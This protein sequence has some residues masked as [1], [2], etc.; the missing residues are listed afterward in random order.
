[1]TPVELFKAGYTD[2]VCV[3]PPGAQLAPN[4]SLKDLGKVPGLKGDDGWHGYNWRKHVPNLRQI[5]KWESWDA[6]TGLR[7]DQF[8]AVDIDV[9]DER[10]ARVVQQVAHRVLGGAPVRRSVGSRRLLPYRTSTPFPRLALVMTW[11]GASHKVEILAAGRQYLIAGKHPSGSDYRWETP[12]PAQAEQLTS[13]DRDKVERFL[14]ELEVQLRRVS[15]M[16]LERVGG[17]VEPAA[18]PPAQDELAAPSPEALEALV[19][20]IPN[21]EEDR[22]GYVRFGH[23]VRAAGGEEAAY[24]FAEWASRWED[25]HNDPDTVDRDYAGF[26]GPYKIGWDWLVRYAAE[27]CRIDPQDEFEADLEAVPPAETGSTIPADTSELG[28]ARHL[29]PSMQDQLAYIGDEKAGYWLAWDGGRW[30]R[31]GSMKPS[32]VVQDACKALSE[33]LQARAD[34]APKKEGAEWAKVAAHLKTAAGIRAVMS[35]LRSGVNPKQED[36]DVD[37][38]ALNTPAGIVDLRTGSVRPSTPADMLTRITAVAPERGPMPLFQKF[39]DESTGGDV[40]LQGFLQRMFGYSLSGDTSAKHLWFVW[41]E[42]DTGKSTFIRIMD[43]IFGEYAD[44]VDVEAFISTDRSRIP[45][46]LARLPGVR[47]VTATEP[48]ANKSWDEKRIKAITGGDNIDARFL[49]GQNFSYKP[50]FKIVIIGNHEP[51]VRTVDTAMLRRIQIVP[52]NV[53]VPREKQVLGL[54]DRIIAEEGP[55][56]MQWLVDGCLQWQE[57]GLRPP[58]CV[59]AKTAQYGEDEDIVAQFLAEMCEVQEGATVTRNEVYRAWSM[60][61]RGRGYIPGGEKQLKGALQPH[62]ARLGFKDSRIGDRRLNGYKN[63]SLRDMNGDF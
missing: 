39:L 29:E 26:G 7:G 50:Q 30:Q 14:S 13:V 3:V 53:P 51:E 55:A 45:A 10:L 41:G 20:E 31:N 52:L 40:E 59:Q 4:T 33:T 43:A 15:G 34:A 49:Y 37:P 61:C 9:D 57:G 44:S 56:V 63:L 18:A 60:W 8:P 21:R 42:A 2:L 23:A 17:G 27:N 1:V 5:K 47:L 24:V 32:R 19:R 11:Q 16:E 46:D 48:P 28:V 54:S 35:L 62:E 36:F 58:Y 25:G 12:L 38:W 22:D 6:N